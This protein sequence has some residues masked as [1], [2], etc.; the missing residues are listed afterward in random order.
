MGFSHPRVEPGTGK[1]MGLNIALGGVSECQDV[2][3]PLYLHRQLLN[4]ITL[5]HLGI[6]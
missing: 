3:N 1:A 2:S 6:K 5:F 4:V